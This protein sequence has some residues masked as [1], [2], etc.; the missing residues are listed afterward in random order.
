MIKIEKKFTLIF[1]R[2]LDDPL[3][4]GA[5][6]TDK[7]YLELQNK[8]TD[9]LEYECFTF[10]IVLKRDVINLTGPGRLIP[11]SVIEKVFADKIHSEFTHKY[12]NTCI[13]FKNIIPTMENICVVFYNAIKGDL[14][15]LYEIQLSNCQDERVTYN[16][17]ELDTLQSYT[18]DCNDY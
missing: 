2:C 1:K 13:Q 5:T 12:L 7:E 14:T 9:D 17:N 6:L 3:L 15:D 11:F 8:S 10:I 16:P 4:N 18:D